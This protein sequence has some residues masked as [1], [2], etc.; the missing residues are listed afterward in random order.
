MQLLAGHFFG[1]LLL[2]NAV[3]AGFGLL[4][5]LVRQA[6]AVA[7]HLGRVIKSAK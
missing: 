2:L 1:Y 7:V 4:C 3:C 6:R 5:L